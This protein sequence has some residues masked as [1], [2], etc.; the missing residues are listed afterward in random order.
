MKVSMRQMSKWAPLLLL[1]PVGASAAL[2]SRV[3][4]FSDGNVLFADQLNTELNNL[5]NGVNSI[6]NDNL[7]TNAN[8]SASKISAS[9]AGSGLT[10]NGTTGVLSVVPDN[11]TIEISANALQVKD[12]GITA[13]KLA[14]DV[15]ANSLP[16]G[17]VLPYA[18][19]TC[20]AGYVI[21]HGDEVSRTGIYAN[22]FAAIGTAHGSG[23]GST[24]FNLPNY[25]GRFLRGVDKG[26][27][28]DQDRA[29]RTSMAAGGNT[30]NAVGTIQG[31]AFQTHNHSVTDPGHFHSYNT[32]ALAG[33]NFLNLSTPQPG[34]N[35]QL[36][37]GSSGSTGSK[38]T[39]VTIV[40]TGASGAHSQASTT[41]TRPANASVNYCVKL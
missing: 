10:R 35:Y 24:T 9:I 26:D 15:T 17:F 5:V 28:L 18:G 20:P 30:G 12:A 21:G 41:E 31:H 11:S 8:I 33:G 6:N 34:A 23:N 7:A 27:N 13:A 38:V 32:P 25:S 40:N 19:T 4:T 36:Y 29:S 2:I 39:G 14:P 22:L 16:P 37:F 3:Y 1:V